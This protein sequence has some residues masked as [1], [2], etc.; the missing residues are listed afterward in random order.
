MEWRSTQC[1]YIVCNPEKIILL[2]VTAYSRCKSRTFV[3]RLGR[4]T[5]SSA[6][7]TTT[8]SSDGQSSEKEL[9]TVL[10]DQR[11]MKAFSTPLLQH[12]SSSP[13]MA[14]TQNAEKY[15]FRVIM[16]SGWRQH[17]MP[18]EEQVNFAGQELLSP[19]SQLMTNNSKITILWYCSFKSLEDV[20]K[21]KKSMWAQPQQNQKSWIHL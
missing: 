10:G 12:P 5:F 9:A 15:F 11:G 13:V 16:R 14:R 1:L 8:T 3:L 7:S 4:V 2:G 6:P 19:L 20:R 21:K 18:K 17:R